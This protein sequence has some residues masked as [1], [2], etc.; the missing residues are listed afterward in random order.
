[1]KNAHL[2][3]IATACLMLSF[4]PLHAAAQHPVAHGCLFPTITSVD[5]ASGPQSGGTSVTITGTNY[6]VGSTTVTFGGVA[7]TAVVVNS[8]TSITAVTPAGA[9]PGAVDVVVT[10]TGCGSDLLKGGFTYTAGA[11]VPAL[12][13]LALAMLAAVLGFVAVI[14]LKR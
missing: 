4:L 6:V 10:V 11:A 13:P 3:M 2:A 7:A 1:M 12:S 9:A 5:P 8:S 14:V